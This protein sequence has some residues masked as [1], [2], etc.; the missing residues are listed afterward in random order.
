MKV[1]DKSIYILCHA[2]CDD[3]FGAVEKGEVSA[4][5]V[6]DFGV[7]EPSRQPEGILTQDA[8]RPSGQPSSQGLVGG[9]TPSD[10]SPSTLAVDEQLTQNQEG[11]FY[12]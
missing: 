2:N 11:M 7:S 8:A 4:R 9:R 5:P 1:N 10:A 3:G 6:F 12:E